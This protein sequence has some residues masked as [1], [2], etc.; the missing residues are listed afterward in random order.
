MALGNIEIKISKSQTLEG[1]APDVGQEREAGKPSVKNE[2]MTV[3]LI[4]V[5]KQVLTQGVQQYANLTGQYAMAETFNAVLSIGADIAI[6][7][8]G[9]VG[10]VA[11]GTKTAL[12]LVSSSV[13]QRIAVR[14]I[15][16]QQSRAGIISTKGS[17]Y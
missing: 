1:E 4:S 13:K 7:A 12:N 5:G 8:T 3:A 14:N 17:R 6:L 15:E 9:P 10:W 2:A 16:L 11:V